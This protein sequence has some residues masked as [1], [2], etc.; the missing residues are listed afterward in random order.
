MAAVGPF[1]LVG[2]PFELLRTVKRIGHVDHIAM[3]RLRLGIGIGDD[4]RLG[5]FTEEKPASCDPQKFS[6]LLGS[7]FGQVLL[8]RQ[9]A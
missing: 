5:V 1:E 2:R 6:K 3:R 9:N 7:S 4:G 8:T